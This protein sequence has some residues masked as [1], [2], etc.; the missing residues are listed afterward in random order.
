MVRWRFGS[1]IA[2][3]AIVACGGSAPEEKTPGP[4]PAPSTRP[5]PSGC[6]TSYETNTPAPPPSP[7]PA[8]SAT[9]TGPCALLDRIENTGTKITG[10]PRLAALDD[11]SLYWPDTTQLSAIPKDGSSSV[12]RLVATSGYFNALV[13]DANAIYWSDG[14]S[15]QR[16][17]KAGGSAQ[18]LADTP[19]ARAVA[20]DATDAYVVLTPA[21]S[22]SLAAPSHVLRVPLSGGAASTAFDTAAPCESLALDDTSIYCQT[23]ASISRFPK[24]GGTPTV[25][26]ELPSLLSMVLADG[27]LYAL[28]YDASKLTR[29]SVDGA[30]LA[31]LDIGAAPRDR[32]FVVESGA[33]YVSVLAGKT[34]RELRRIP[35]DGSAIGRLPATDFSLAELTAD[36]TGLYWVDTRQTCLHS[37]TS[38]PIGKGS[39]GGFT[40]HEYL[41]ELRAMRAPLAF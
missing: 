10:A 16:L 35:L 40:C 31:P 37:T 21:P 39:G 5:D 8:C 17:A 7:Y 38:V 28:Q 27:T 29:L 32:S 9:A 11:T 41:F 12:A 24:A 25:L 22:E 13:V 34:Q 20:I 14:T 19:W 4:P 33:A 26:L 23:T 15:L 3:L 2:V 18:K 36:A 30:P 1:S 6:C